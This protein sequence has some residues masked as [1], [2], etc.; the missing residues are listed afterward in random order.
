MCNTKNLSI[1]KN[2]S[3]QHSELDDIHGF[4]HTERVLRLCMKI[5]KQLGADLY[6]LKI[7]AL[8]H[9]IGRKF[10]LIDHA[11]RNHANISTQMA[12]DFLNNTD[13][14]LSKKD[15]EN[16]VHCIKAHS[17]SN[18]INPTT[19]EAKILSDADKLDTIGAIGLYRTI[20]FTILSK[21]GIDQVIKHLEDKILKIYDQLYLD[22]SRQI[23]I[24]RQRIILDFY[25][26][27]KN[28]LD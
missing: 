7:S 25:S 28:E 24:K 26:Q 2:F 17:Y 3:L 4:L 12:L 10:E 5:G 27:I 20:A 9:D 18:N 16:I 11:K 15:I 22:L 1:I 8:L 19:L 13:L 21:G 14:E 6:I 23:A